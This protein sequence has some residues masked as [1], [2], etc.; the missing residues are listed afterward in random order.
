MELPELGLLYELKRAEPA[1]ETATGRKPGR[2]PR[3][4]LRPLRERAAA[5]LL[6]LAGRLATATP[7][8]LAAPELAAGE[9]PA[10]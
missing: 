4:S 6:G 5:T 9:Q 7:D 2:R 10:R 8:A 3:R 1:R